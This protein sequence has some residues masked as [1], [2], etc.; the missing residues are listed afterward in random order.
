MRGFH[1]VRLCVSPRC[2]LT[3]GCQHRGTF[4][5]SRTQIIERL[6]GLPQWVACRFGYDAD[7]RC[8]TE[9]FDAVLAREIGD[10]QYLPL[11]P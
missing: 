3:L 9:E 4:K 10:R 5:P 1:P 8:G 11:L 6:V 7:L 2:S